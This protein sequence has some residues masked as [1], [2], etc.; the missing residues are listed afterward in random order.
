MFRLVVHVLPAKPLLV[1][2]FLYVGDGLN[3]LPV[4]A[5]QI[6]DQRHFVAHDQALRRLFGGLAV[7]KAPPDGDQEGEQQERP[8]NAQDSQDAAALVAEG[9]LS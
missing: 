3:L 1:Y 4:I 8:S 2:H 9:V 6:E 5:G 7:I